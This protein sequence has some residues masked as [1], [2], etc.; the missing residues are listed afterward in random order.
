MAVEAVRGTSRKPASSRALDELISRQTDLSGCLY[1]GYP[2][3]STVEGP[4]AIDALLVTA[5]KGIIVFDLIEG[6]DSGDYGSRQDDSANRLEA[7]LRVHR[8]LTR[9]RDLLIPIYTISFAPGIADPTSCAED[10]YPLAN[11]LSLMFELDR[12]RWKD[13]D[14]K[15]YGH[16]L[17]AIQNISTIRKSSRYRTITRE[18]SR[19]A[20]LRRLENSIATLDN[21]QSRGVIETVEGVQ[22][23]RGLAGSG[24]TIVLALKAAYLHAQHPDWRIAVTFFTR[25]LKGYFHR[26]INTFSL[27]TGEEPDWNRLRIVH[28]W[29]APGSADRNGIY[30]EFCRTHGVE[31]LDFAAARKKFGR[32]RAFVGACQ[33]A[34]DQAGEEKRR[35]DAILVDEAQDFSPP[36]LRLCYKL[37][38]DPRRLV[39]AY[40]ELQS[41]SGESLPPSEDIFGRR[42]DGSPRVQLGHAKGNG[43]QD[44]VIF[45]RCYRNSRPVLV[46]AHALGFGIYRTPSRS[47]D[48]GLVQMFDHPE[49]WEEIG[50]RV[51]EGR[52][53]EGSFVALRRSEETSPKF[54][55]DH[56]D[57][58]DLIRFI[59]FDSEEDQADWLTKAIKRNLEDEELRHD[60]IIVINPDP[61]STRKRVGPIRARLLR[62]GIDCHTAGVDTSPDIFFRRNSD[63]VTFTGIYRAKGNEAGMVYVI[64]AQD[65]HSTALN[66]ARG[67]NQIF[68][69]ITRSQAW[70]RVLGVGPKMKEVKRE[71]EKLTAANFELKFTYPTREQRKRLRIGH[72]DMTEA[73][74]NRLKNRQKNLD[75]LVQDLEA[76]NL[77]PEDLGKSTVAKLKQFLLSS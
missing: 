33:R 2:I 52:L 31:Y 9:R 61:V 32:D 7:R 8:E 35:Y 45:E 62:M 13:A 57:I 18:D 38:K 56:S 42:A 53:K 54:L 29:G 22:R 67:R 28:A 66:L 77:H 27:Q 72:R 10:G 69:A 6:T 20:K 64:N 41:L 40:D 11:S 55:E 43:S 75:D 26:L 25:S 24:K 58:D 23:I 37:L 15:V 76:G 5:D 21:D 16:A 70:I 19:G 65:C 51:H 71:Y 3:I 60:D 39:Y 12:F 36:F 34:L 68:T 48:L 17:S 30:Y 14:G 74:H 46:T 73:D 1:I 4:H 63:S 49:L 59:P 50:Y 47:S 44:D